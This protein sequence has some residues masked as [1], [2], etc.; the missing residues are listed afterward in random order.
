MEPR[1]GADFSGVR[2][3]TGSES[4]QLNRSVSAQAFTLGQDIYLG[5][6]KDDLESAQGKQLLAHELTHVVQQ[7]DRQIARAKRIDQALQRTYENG[8]TQHLIQRSR[9]LAIGQMRSSVIQ[10]TAQEN[11]QILQSVPTAAADAS[12]STEGSKDDTIRTMAEEPFITGTTGTWHHIFPRNLLKTHLENISKYFV[13]TNGKKAQMSETG[14]SHKAMLVMAASFS[15]NE[16]GKLTKPAHYYWKHGN[17]YLG[18]RSDYRT[19]DPG[20]LVEHKKPASMGSDRYNKPRSWGKELEKLSV[21]LGKLSELN[22]EEEL[23]G[24][25]SAISKLAA[26]IATFS[27]ELDGDAYRTVG[28]ED[29]DWQRASKTIAWGQASKNYKLVGG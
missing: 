11:L 2:I 6:G 24:V 9:P 3:H 1:F 25:D 8:D 5:E 4:A 17:G 22:N 18:V 29:K 19:D 7:T 28:K 13:A 16:N 12:Y 15:M 26:N 23:S 21:D 27:Q 20:S 10:R 14:T